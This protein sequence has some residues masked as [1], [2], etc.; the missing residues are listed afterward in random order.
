MHQSP[1]LQ[2]W[3]VHITRTQIVISKTVPGPCLPQATVQQTSS[4]SSMTEVLDPLTYR[5][6][7]PHPE[8]IPKQNKTLPALLQQI[9]CL[10]QKQ[11]KTQVEGTKLWNT[12][13]IQTRM[14]HAFNKMSF[15]YFIHILPTLYE[16]VLQVTT[17]CKSILLC[18][19]PRTNRRWHT[20]V[21]K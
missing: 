12:N 2:A 6:I 14:L 20:K 3:R 7:R 16:K 15:F 1:L 21:L 17:M 11:K 18:V 19:K 13:T 9:T 5:K 10:S 8:Y 4:F